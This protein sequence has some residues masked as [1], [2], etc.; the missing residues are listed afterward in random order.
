MPFRSLTH[1]ALR[2]QSLPQAERLYQQLFGMQVAYREALA[3]DGWR[4]LRE[5]L[6]WEKAAS[7]GVSPGMTVL[8]RDA[9]T[10][11][12]EAVDE[13]GAPGIL[14]HIGLLVDETELEATRS[15]A[16][17]AGCSIVLDTPSLIVVMDSL[18]VQWEVT[19]S[20]QEDPRAGSHGARSGRW[21]DSVH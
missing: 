10:L 14:D 7:L 1:I 15:H 11:A 3:P 16:Q 9:F 2:V 17:E 21:L 13:G 20:V 6:D 4:T 5:G 19:T 12:L 18:G 8:H